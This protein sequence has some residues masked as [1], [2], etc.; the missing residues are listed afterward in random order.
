MKENY[1]LNASIFALFD[2]QETQFFLSSIHLFDCTFSKIL[3]YN[4]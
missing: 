2:I 3:V 1:E 4:L